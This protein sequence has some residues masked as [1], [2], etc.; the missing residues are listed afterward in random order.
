M[1]SIRHSSRIHFTPP[2]TTSRALLLGPQANVFD[3]LATRASFLTSKA[4]FSGGFSAAICG[5]ATPRL[6][7]GRRGVIRASGGGPEGAGKSAGGKREERA[8]PTAETSPLVRFA[9]YASEAFG[10]AVATVRG[11]EAEGGKGKGATAE[12][13]PAVV[14]RDAAIKALREDYDKSYFV[15]GEMTMWLYEPD[16]EFA[17]PFVSFN[18]RDRFKQNVSN[19]GSFMEE[20]SL[21]ILDWQESEG[22]VTTKWR[23]SCVLGLPWRPILAASGST[24]HFFNESTGKIYK[25]VERWDISPADGVKQLLKPNP[26]LRKR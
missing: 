17:D 8:G 10:K 12:G 7:G 24:D 16:C 2:R 21:K 26:K 14:E 23:F 20:V 22:T 18:G 5:T 15:T 11:G 25:H 9:W 4:A 6:S 3:G 1:D 13:E 19:L